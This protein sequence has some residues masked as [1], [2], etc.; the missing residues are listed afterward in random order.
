[1]TARPRAEI[2]DDYRKVL[3][4]IYDPAAYCARLERMLGM[5]KLTRKPRRFPMGDP[6]RQRELEAVERVINIF[7]EWRD[8]LSQTFARC[9][10]A[11]PRAVRQTVSQLALFLHL[12]PYSRQIV[13]ETGK[14]IAEIDSG[15]FTP[16]M[17][18]SMLAAEE[19]QARRA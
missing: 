8:L 11:N 15:T 10:K 18:A 16:P 6:R 3:T 7:P 1:V 17:L 14:A 4:Q 9:F 5:L 19:P 2:L 13:A 12:I